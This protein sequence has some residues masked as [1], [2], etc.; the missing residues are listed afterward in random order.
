MHT[1]HTH[2]AYFTDSRAVHVKVYLLVV[3]LD[4]TFVF[5]YHLQLNYGIKTAKFSNI[6]VPLMMQ[7]IARAIYQYGY[8]SPK[9]FWLQTSM[10]LRFATSTQC[11]YAKSL[12]IT[13]RYS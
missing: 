5:D 11:I 10:I 7:P 12:N 2:S 6:C 8:I 9:H 4:S 3:T 1:M 13:R